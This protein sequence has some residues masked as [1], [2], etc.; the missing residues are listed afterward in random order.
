MSCNIVTGAGYRHPPI[1]PSQALGMEKAGDS[2][3]R[4]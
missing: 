1:A 2:L 4:R 3:H